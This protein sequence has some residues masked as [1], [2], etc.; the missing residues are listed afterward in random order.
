MSR[1]EAR[2]RTEDWNEIYSPGIPVAVEKNKV[3]IETVTESLAFVMGGLPVIWLKGISGNT[4][5]CKVT[6]L[7]KPEP[8]K[9]EI[10]LARVKKG[11][12]A[13]KKKKSKK[14]SKKKQ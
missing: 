4:N 6:P 2:G 8:K 9:D 12:K 13:G 11:G 3:V 7:V 5:L 14:A 10:V 1:V